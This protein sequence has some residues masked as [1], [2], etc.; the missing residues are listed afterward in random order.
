MSITNCNVGY[1]IATLPVGYIDANGAAH[2][3]VAL[4]RAH[5]EQRLIQ[6]QSA[7]EKSYKQRLPPSLLYEA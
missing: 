7:W 5:D 3:L 1:P 4:A 6:L 2:G